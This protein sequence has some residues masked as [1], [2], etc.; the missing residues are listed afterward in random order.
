[1]TTL[2]Q[3]RRFDSEQDDL[4]IVLHWYDLLCPF[5]YVGQ[6]RTTILLRHGL[7]VVELPFQAHPDI[8]PGGI[9]AGPRNGPICAMLERE[10]RDPLDAG[11]RDTQSRRQPIQTAAYGG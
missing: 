1:M 8:P 9:P 6:N 5:C 3:R 2:T 4:D 7:D 11:R 10:A